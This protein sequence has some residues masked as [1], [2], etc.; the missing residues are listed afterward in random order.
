MASAA[1]ILSIL[2]QCCAS[3]TFPMLDNGYIYPA[4]HRLSVHHAPDNW[5]LV[6]EL[7]GYSP[8]AGLPDTT[9]LTFAGKLHNRNTRAAYVSDDAYQN[10][11]KHNPHN[12]DRR[13]WPIEDEGWIDQE[14]GETLA[15][16][17]SKF[18]LRGRTMRT[19]PSEV[20][21]AHGIELSEQPRVMVFEFCRWLAGEHREDVLAT[22]AERRVSLDPA[23]QEILMLDDWHHPDL[24]G[25]EVASQSE[26][27]RQLAQVLATGVGSEYL[28]TQKPNTHWRN[29]PEGGT[30]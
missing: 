10:Y 19:P 29:W 11:L 12:E 18:L 26:T 15:G 14:D 8:R 27:F 7:F 21:A 4:A 17:G 5:A 24:A 2:D 6:F 30:L 22:Q 23:L 25:G 20:Y 9:I 13:V 16:A 28:P 3:Y 1:E